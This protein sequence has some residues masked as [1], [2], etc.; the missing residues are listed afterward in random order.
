VKL[1]SV[2]ASGQLQQITGKGPQPVLVR[3]FLFLEIN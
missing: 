1:R 2:H 3:A